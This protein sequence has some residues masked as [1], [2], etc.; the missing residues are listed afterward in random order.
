MP[1]NE[2]SL[3]EKENIQLAMAERVLYKIIDSELE[4]VPI[5][6]INQ[7]RKQNYPKAKK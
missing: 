1:K 3:E 4:H 6:S 2:L 7:E 5:R